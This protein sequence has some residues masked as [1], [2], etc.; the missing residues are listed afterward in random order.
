MNSKE[1]IFIENKEKV[2]DSTVEEGSDMWSES[3]IENQEKNIK[4]LELSY[5]TLQE[6]LSNISV[7][8]QLKD[9]Q[10]QQD[11][12]K[13]K[14]SLFTTL[15]K[16]GSNLREDIL[17]IFSSNKKLSTE[18]QNQYNNYLDE[19]KD[20]LLKNRLFYKGQ[21][22]DNPHEDLWTKELQKHK[23]PLFGNYGETGDYLGKIAGLDELSP[24]SNI[25]KKIYDLNII[26]S[27]RLNVSDAPSGYA[28][29]FINISNLPF[30]IAKG[31]KKFTG[32]QEYLDK[33]VEIVGTERRFVTTVL[34]ESIHA[35]L[36]YKLNS[37]KTPEER[38]VADKL[39]TVF[40]EVKNAVSPI[41]QQQYGFTDLDEFMAEFFTNG[42]FR[43]IVSN[44]TINKEKLDKN[45]HENY[46]IEQYI[47]IKIR[48]LIEGILQIPNPADS[49]LLKGISGDMIKE[50]TTE[51][52]GADIFVEDLEID[53]DNQGT[54]DLAKKEWK[55]KKE[56]TS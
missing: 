25:A 35:L 20:E 30:K 5:D 3:S 48:N 11:Y 4:D 41:E 1:N 42:E 54:I 10:L 13:E 36:L 39:Y 21:S 43:R 46:Q 51:L 47:R 14:Q 9:P 6:D 16:A 28:G 38:L 33:F 29:G 17:K 8:D 12:L 50:L 26:N 37:P 15:T 24:T 19:R 45:Y 22:L 55:E 44:I 52:I 56:I 53:L 49:T 7:P 32:N 31:E 18:E 34:H 40:N 2:E 23:S 27:L